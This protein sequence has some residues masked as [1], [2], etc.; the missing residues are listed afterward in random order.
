MLFLTRKIG[1]A[2]IINNDIEITVQEITGSK[3]KLGIVYPKTASVLRK[4]I[5][6]RIQQENAEATLSA[7]ALQDAIRSHKKDESFHD[8][9][10][11]ATHLE[12][13]IKKQVVNA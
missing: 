10:D 1:E 13:M 4:E 8:D 12:N 6:D 9:S 5:F 11:D 2:I 3:V 7:E